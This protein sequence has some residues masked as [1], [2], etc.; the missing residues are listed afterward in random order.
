MHRGDPAVADGRGHATL[1]IGRLR[2]CRGRPRARP[3]RAG[4]RAGVPT[5]IV[6]PWSS[7]WIRSHSRMI[8]RMSCSIT[9]SPQ[10]KSSRIAQRWPTSSSLSASLARR[11]ARRAAGTRPRGERARDAEPA[12]VAVGSAAARSPARSRE[13]HHVEHLARR[14]RAPRAR[15]RA[16]ATAAGLDVLEHGEAART[17]AT[18]WNVRASPRA[19]EPVR[20]PAGDVDAVRAGRC[21]GRRAGS[22]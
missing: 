19:R 4:P 2:G 20:R 12:L 11:P 10:P 1:S 7:T 3:G 9:S 21:P 22:R 14:R 5:A 8:R 16:G 15:R 18:F 17:G 13:P 6:L